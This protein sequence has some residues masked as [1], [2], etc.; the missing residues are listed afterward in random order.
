MLRHVVMFRFAPESTREQVD[1]HGRRACAALPA[2]IPE[3]RGYDVGPN[4]GESP[5]QLGLRGG[6]RLRRRVDD[7]AHYVAD[8]SATRRSSRS[9]SDPIVTERAAVQYEL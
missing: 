5:G 8:A 2:A 1:A 3:I 7:I 6:R 9:A 4:V